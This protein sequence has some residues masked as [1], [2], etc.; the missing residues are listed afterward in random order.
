MR[1][2]TRD[3]VKRRAFSL[4]STDESNHAGKYRI[5]SCAPNDE[6][7]ATR[8]LRLYALFPLQVGERKRL[9]RPVIL[10][11]RAVRCAVRLDVG[12]AQLSVDAELK[13]SGQY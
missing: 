7:L 6:T 2:R 3:A 1:A 13:G 11:R 9:A 5:Y 12:H 4:P 10:D 8:R